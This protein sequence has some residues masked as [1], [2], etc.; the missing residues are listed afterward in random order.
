M[1][2]DNIMLWAYNMLS[3]DNTDNML[4]VY[5][6]LSVSENMLSVDNM[7]SADNI[8]LSDDILSDDNIML[9]Y[10]FFLENFTHS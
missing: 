5:I 7:L 9:S 8:T 6:I 1:L 4:S 3:N 2:A 10:F